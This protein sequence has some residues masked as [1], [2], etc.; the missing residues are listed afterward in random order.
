MY[1]TTLTSQGTL[2]LPAAVR[3]KHNIRPGDI[4]TIEDTDEI[5]VIVNAR[6][7]DMRK[8]NQIYAKS[9]RAYKQGDGIATHVAEKYGKK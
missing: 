5:R 4:L 8:K 6:F 9:A 2:S 3:R 1:Q 7:V